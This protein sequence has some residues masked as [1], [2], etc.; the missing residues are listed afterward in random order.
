MCTKVALHRKIVTYEIAIFRLFAEIVLRKT[1]ADYE[2]IIRV[3]VLWSV[4]IST[5]HG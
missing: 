5:E 3:F 2:N 1:L 4:V